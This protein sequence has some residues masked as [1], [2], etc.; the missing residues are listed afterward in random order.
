MESS[1]VSYLIDAFGMLGAAALLYAYAM[2]SMAKMS[3]GGLAYQLIN[4][5]G[6]VALMV[7]SAYHFAWPSAVLN[8]VWCGIGVLALTRII[9]ARPWKRGR[10]S[11]GG[12]G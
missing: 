4:L 6:A 5:G 8:L 11:G 3:G 12:R 7:N 10:S 9:A 2:L 1:V